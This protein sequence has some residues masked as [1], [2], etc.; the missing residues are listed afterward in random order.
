LHLGD[1]LPDWRL[2]GAESSTSR[3]NP[4]VHHMK[5]VARKRT[6]ATFGTL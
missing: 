3:P 4:E 2:P 1:A 5:F 6:A